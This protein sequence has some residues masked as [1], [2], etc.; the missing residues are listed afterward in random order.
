MDIENSHYALCI[1]FLFPSVIELGMDTWVIDSPHQRTC[2]FLASIF[3]SILPSKHGWYV[4]S[5]DKYIHK[6]NHQKYI[7]KNLLDIDELIPIQDN[8]SL[9]IEVSQFVFSY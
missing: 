7:G 2:K 3:I 4:W 8:K 1:I 9:I 6:Q 5:L